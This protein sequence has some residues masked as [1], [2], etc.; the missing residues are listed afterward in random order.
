MSS[1]NLR[2]AAQV[3]RGKAK[4]PKKVYGLP[5]LAIPYFSGQPNF[6]LLV[7]TSHSVT[8]RTLRL[9]SNI[10]SLSVLR[11]FRGYAAVPFSCGRMIAKPVKSTG[12]STPPQLSERADAD[13]CL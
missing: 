8:F 12:T 6:N 11:W 2:Q 10:V 13:A 3:A 9:A 1:E 7:E 4:A 5:V